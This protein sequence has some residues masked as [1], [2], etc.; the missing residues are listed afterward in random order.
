MFSTYRPQAVKRS[1][2]TPIEGWVFRKDSMMFALALI[3]ALSVLALASAV[4]LADSG[5]RWWSAFGQLRGELKGSRNVERRA[6]TRARLRPLVVANRHAAAPS[7]TLAGVS[8]TR[9]A[10]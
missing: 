6:V 10:A 3:A 5:L 9:V 4:V 8:V 2:D 7:R 1:V